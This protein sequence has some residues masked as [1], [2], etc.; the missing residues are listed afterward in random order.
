MDNYLPAISILVGI[1]VFI[2]GYVERCNRDRRRHTFEFFRSIIEEKG[3]IHEANL[4]LGVWISNGRR[5]ENDEIELEDYM[6]IV[7]LLD[8]Y[9]FVSVTA[10]K[11]FLDRSTVVLLIGA[12]MSTTYFILADYINARRMKLCRPHLYWSFERFVKK[13]I[14]DRYL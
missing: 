7:T 1:V 8:Y 2:I 14:G 6:T 3:P 11:N 9:D 12:R 13:D 4:Q 10:S 5:F